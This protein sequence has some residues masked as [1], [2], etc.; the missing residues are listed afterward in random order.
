[1]QSVLGLF[2]Q[3]KIFLLGHKKVWVIFYAMR[4]KKVYKKYL[5]RAAPIN[6]IFPCCGIFFTPLRLLFD[7]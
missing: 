7:D 3:I 5:S 6:K 2:L 1:M 4:F